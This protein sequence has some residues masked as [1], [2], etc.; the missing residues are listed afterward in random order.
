MNILSYKLYKKDNATTI[1]F[2]HGFMENHKMWID[3]AKR[4]KEKYQIILIDLPGH[5]KSDV[6]NEVNTMQFMSDMV[7]EVLNSL[8]IK[9]SIF[10]GHSMGGYVIMDLLRKY[11]P[12]I[13]KYCLF[14][15]SP[16]EDNEEKKKNRLRAV[17]LVKKN[18]D[19]FISV[20]TP[21]L[22]NQNK[23]DELSEEIAFAKK[24]GFE[25]SLEGI[26]SA[27]L[28]MREREDSTELFNLC[29][30]PCLL[31]SGK[32]DN[33]VSLEKLKSDLIFNEVREH[34]VLPC[35]HMGYLEAKE[36]SF[37]ALNKFFES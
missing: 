25:T 32:Y 11:K 12:Y 24:M 14:F 7:I 29:T 20:S 4:L 36:D 9:Q 2:L 17:E 16:F 21:N 13:R 37:N 10:A 31:I 3:Y 35:G 1:V 27:L 18:K 30:I 8:N 22:F 19:S 5:G 33:A 6:Y 28:G 15:S 26:T 23:L 34:V